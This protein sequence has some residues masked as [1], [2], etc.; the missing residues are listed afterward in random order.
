MRRL[1]SY[2]LG[3]PP[4]RV[5]GGP[6]MALVLDA[7]AQDMIEG[8]K[9]RQALEMAMDLGYEELAAELLHRLWLSQQSS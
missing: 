2:S 6:R 9:M 8:F 1:L 4:P 5:A 7:V 3:Y